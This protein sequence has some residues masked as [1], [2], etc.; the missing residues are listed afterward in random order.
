MIIKIFSWLYWFALLNSQYPRKT[1]FGGFGEER[2][3]RKMIDVF[4][5]FIMIPHVLENRRE[6]EILIENV[7]SSK[8]LMF[9]LLFLIGKS[10][11]CIWG[12]I[13]KFL[14]QCEHHMFY[15]FRF[16]TLIFNSA[17]RGGSPN[18]LHIWKFKFKY[19]L[20]ISKNPQNY[21]GMPHPSPIPSNLMNRFDKAWNSA[22]LAY[23]SSL[24]IRG[25]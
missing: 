22:K 11:F 24:F 6:V 9:S 8:H 17:N 23:D 16:I 18:S 14:P 1:E 20:I 12:K 19:K 13:I 15:L 10:S 4:G 5:L 21:R 25:F 2:Q 7:K 3:K